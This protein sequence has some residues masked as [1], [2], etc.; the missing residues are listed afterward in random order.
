MYILDYFVF[1]MREI[2]QLPD[3]RNDLFKDGQPELSF[4]EKNYPDIYSK[5]KEHNIN[6]DGP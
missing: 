2:V 4:F 6:F 3:N 5:L 1:K